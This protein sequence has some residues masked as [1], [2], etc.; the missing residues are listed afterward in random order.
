VSRVEDCKIVELPRIVNPQGNLTFVEGGRHVPFDLQRVFYVYDVPA[1]SYRGAHAHKTLDE[2]LVCI[3]GSLDVRVNDGRRKAT[4]T[5][6]RPWLGLHVPPMIW[7]EEDNFATG[8][9]YLVLA[10]HRYDAG[11]YIRD[12]DTFVGLNR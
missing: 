6:N 3:T 1:G 7:A 8:T 5:L 12:Y 4:F 11:D 2:V 10:S 9:V